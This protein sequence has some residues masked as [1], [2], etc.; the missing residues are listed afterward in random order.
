MNVEHVANDGYYLTQLNWSAP[1]IEINVPVTIRWA[2]DKL[3]ENLM[4]SESQD[5]DAAGEDD[6]E[7]DGE[8]DEEGV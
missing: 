8:S 3:R 1:D 5:G 2:D 6:G 4:R 7:E